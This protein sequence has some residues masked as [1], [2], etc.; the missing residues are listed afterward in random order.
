[1]LSNARDNRVRL[2]ALEGGRTAFSIASGPITMGKTE[3]LGFVLRQLSDKAFRQTLYMPR[4]LQIDG[5]D[6]RVIP[7]DH[8]PAHVHVVKRP[9]E[10]VFNLNCPSGPVEL[11]EEHNCSIQEVNLLE[12]HLNK[13]VPSLC[14]GWR[15]YHVHKS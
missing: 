12:S 14:A 15:K 2:S 1:M 6:V 4:I 13:H 3:R 5:W 8:R 7:G 9:S 11:R 10:A